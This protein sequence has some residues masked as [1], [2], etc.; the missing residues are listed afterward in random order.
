M[1]VIFLGDV[2]QRCSSGSTSSSLA[3]TCQQYVHV[4]SSGPVRVFAAR[5]N[6]SIRTTL[7]MRE[8]TGYANL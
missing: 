4:K 1:V 7:R 2:V 5:R 8:R 3:P 6:I